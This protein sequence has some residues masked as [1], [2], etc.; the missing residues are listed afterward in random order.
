MKGILL[1]TVVA[2]TITF[3]VFGNSHQPP[4]PYEFVAG[5]V[6]QDTIPPKDRTG[7]FINNPSSNPFDLKDPSIITKEV[8][9]DPTTNRYIIIERIGDDY[10][11]AP[12]YM[13]FEEYLKYK[14]KQQEQSYFNRLAGVGK[15]DKSGL[16]ANNPLGNI[17][18][19]KNLADR[20]FGGSE[21]DIRPQGS[22]DLSFG[23]NY[24]RIENPILPERARTNIIPIDFRMNIQMNVTGSIGSKLNIN[25]NYNTQA[26]FDFD[27]IM[28]L[29]YASDAFN[30]DDIVK[31]IE[32]GN[33]SLPLKGSLIT[34]AQS[35]FGV[36]TQLQFGRLYL[37]GVASQQ[38]SDRK[39]IQ[40]KGGSQVQTY[41]VFADEY[42]EN[43]HFLLSHFN[44]E[45]FEPALENL[46]QILSL[47]TIEQI[48]VWVT[49]DR[50]E[51]AREGQPGPRDILALADLGEG[52]VLTS[53]DKVNINPASPR[54]ITGNF[55][56]PSNAVNDI[57]QTATADPQ[58]RRIERA[59]AILQNRLGF[60][61]AKDFEKVNARR[62]REGA[63]YTVNRELGFI[64]ININLRQDQVLGVAFQYSYNGR[65]YKVGELFNDQSAT[66]ADSSQQVLFVK[67]L[68]STTPRVDLPAWDLMMKNFYNIG[69]YQVNRKDFKLDVYYEDPG[70][71]Q[72]R[73]LP[74]SIGTVESRQPLI[75]LFNLDNLN[76]QGDPGQ[77]G[78]FDFVP[79]LTIYPRTGRIMFPVLEPFGSHL[80]NVRA[81]DGSPLLNEEDI[82]RFVYQ[83]LYDSTVI[84]AREFPEK[85]RF[86]VRG[87]YRSAVSSEISLGAFNIPPGSVQ[88]TAGGTLLKE[89]IDYEIDYNIGRVKI[90]ND[91]YLSS[92]V[93]I[94]ASFEDNSLFGFQTK[95]LVGLRADYKFSEEFN[96]GAT[97][98]KL[99]QR[100]FTQKVNL[101]DDP[102]NNSIYGL[103]INFSRDAPWL[104]RFVDRIP[105]IDTKA[106]SRISFNAEAAALQ[107][108]HSKAIN[109]QAGEDQGGIVYI[110]DFEGSVSS[111]DL[112]QP[113]N[114]WVISSV[115]QNDEGNNNPLFPEAALIDDIRGGANR[116]L[117]N[118]YR[119]DPQLRQTEASG[120]ENPYTT[121]I[122]LT[123]VFP[124]RQNTPDQL[125]TIQ[126]FDLA[127]YPDLRG[128]YNYDIPNGYP[129][130]SSG[131]TQS[132]ALK[133]PT[134]RWGGIMRALNINNFEQSNIQFIEFWMLSPFLNEPGNPNLEGDMYINL[135]NISEDILR[136]S[137]K[138]FENGLPGPANPNR[139]TNTTNWSVI[140]LAQQITNAFDVD[141]ATRALQDVGLDGLDSDKERE[142]YAD[143]LNSIQSSD[144]SATAKETVLNDPSNDDYR[145]YSDYPQ[146]TNILE[147]YMKFNHTEGNSQPPTD[148]AF[149]ATNIPDSEDLNRDQTLN[150]TESYF[151]FRVPIRA[152]GNGVQLNS[153]IT[154]ERTVNEGTPN[155]RKWYRYRIPLNDPA[156]R[157]SIGGIQ[158]FRSIRFMRVYLQGFAQPVVLRFARF[159]L[160][161]NQ[162]RVYQQ[163]LSN[164][165]ADFPTAFD[166]N[167]VN[168]EA[169]SS[170]CPFN[171]VLPEGIRREN[172]IGV[173]NAL[174]N[175]QSISLGV[176]N[177]ADGDARGIYKTL[178]LDMRNYERL[179]MFVHAEKLGYNECGDS[180]EDVLCDPDLN[181]GD[182]TVFVRM[183]SDFQDNYYEYEIPL[184][185]SSIENLPMLGIGQAATSAYLREIWPKENEFDFPLDWLV[186]AK[187]A[188]NK[189]GNAAE[190]FFYIPP[191]GLPQGH[192]IKVKGNPNLGYV[193]TIMIG[194]RNPK[195]DGKPHCIEIWANE[196]RLQGLNEQGGVAALARLDLQLADFGNLSLSGN[197]NSIGFGSIE[198][199]VDQR[200]LEEIKGFDIAG[201]FELS[202]FLPAAWGLRLPAYGAYS[203]LSSTP[204]FDPLDLDVLLA[205]KLANAETIQDRDSIRDLSQKVTEIKT[206]SLNNVGKQRTSQSAPM[207]WDI[208]NFSASYAFSETENRDPII[209]YDRIKNHQ[210][211]L[212]YGFN[213]R[214]K[215][216]EPFKKL[217]QSNWYKPL[218]DF[219]FNPVPN[220][221]T[222]STGMYREVSEV[223]YRFTDLDP[224]FSTFYNK[225]FT[226]DRNVGVNWDMAKSL[227][228]NFVSNGF[229]IIDEPDEARLREQ[230]L[231]PDQVREIIQDSIRTNVLVGG[232]PKNYNHSVGVNFTAP[233]RSIPILDWINL[234]AQY[235]ANYSWTAA[236]LNVQNLGNIIQNNQRR[237]VSGDFDFEKLYDKSNYL[238]QVNRAPNPNANN[239]SRRPTTPNKNDE[240]KDKKEK[241]PRKVSSSE[242]MIL[243]PL[244]A[245]RRGRLTYSED[246]ATVVPGFT[247]QTSILGLSR[248]FDAPGLDFVAGFQPNI[249]NLKPEQYGTAEDWLH[250][251]S[252]ARRENSW[253]TNDVLLNQQVAQ[254]YQ[255]NLDAQLTLEP[256]RDFR[257]DINAKR[258]FVQNHTQYFKDTL[259]VGVP[260]WVHAVPRDV[261]SLNMSYFALN[262]F[263]KDDIGEIISLFKE[264]EENRIV[265]SQLLGTG[266]HADS[267]LARQGYTDGYGRIQQDV[268]IASFIA[269]YTGKSPEE[270]KV[271]DDY[272]GNVLFKQLPFP[273]WRLT[274]SGLSKIPMFKDIFRSVNISHGY[275]SSL[276][277]NTFQTDLDFLQ[278][279]GGLNPL[280]QDFYSQLEIPEVVIQEAFAPL[281]GV[282]MRFQN[283]L[284][285]NLNFAKS[286]TLAMSFV[287]NQLAETQSQQY[288]VGAG[289]KIQNVQIG[290][291]KKMVGNTADTGGRNRDATP[292]N[293]LRQGGRRGG[294]GAN[295]NDLDI[296]IDFAWRDNVTF[297]HILDQNIT[298]PTRGTRQINFSP[299]IQYQL[300]NQLALRLFFDY[301]RTVPKI[302][303]SF[304]ITN[305]SGGIVIRFTLN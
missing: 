241:E 73:F 203:R 250:Q 268:L 138:F 149:S 70:A 220:S 278:S 217:P 129:G 65:T 245:I 78:V 121:R 14:A 266:I 180:Q 260:N 282:D 262:T 31:S 63:E 231:T 301:N 102:I 101:G 242:R 2:V 155:E 135:G 158:D 140:P 80:R 21:V 257:I 29:S 30:E 71:G 68:K 279:N 171:Y 214:T 96:I 77:D 133:D 239:S 189:D 191:T 150:E 86:V 60:Q 132:G 74:T 79:E 125:P 151:Q 281:L 163:P 224:V 148:G 137:Q 126:S 197:Y 294:G 41:E 243:R 89:G 11:R 211:S 34:G 131:L 49:N 265:V 130:I 165:L 183:G 55:L 174:Q 201:N 120:L 119:I 187:L 147:R 181:D 188:R 190:E 44:R 87:E 161:R 247:P 185:L 59:V 51:T 272:V 160:V 255:Q 139:R 212:D 64:S 166:V 32:A 259:G 234:R 85:N 107:P 7:D 18:I 170:R 58:A 40:I 19:K 13:T 289:W 25:T 178:N 267:L 276:Q 210:G 118:W 288:T 72:K 167:A 97:A 104:T 205:E 36:K 116:A 302:S 193:K 175:E 195:D 27:N 271:Q 48:D 269:S 253:I 5:T 196:L 94:R 184:Q 225:Q 22:I 76:V 207:P 226:W 222:F 75:R 228:F 141:E 263:F 164:E 50:N 4:N 54:D 95:T 24:S 83:Q 273:N 182:V 46:P 127:Y 61:Q 275:Q 304:P 20:L 218:R 8:E 93:P 26:T 156:I 230:G 252:N 45:L 223:K 284:S 52:N 244:L 56:L 67:M 221:F 254:Q 292:N 122:D 177:L 6:Q 136:D 299:S 298:D 162:W 303:S 287:S 28:K 236:A 227:K 157:R 128:P 290:F 219:N 66:G 145:Y 283:N 108:G 134:T 99:L 115:P 35:L 47:F 84:F 81:S 114:A 291:L 204:K 152:N 274:Y 300:I 215:Y 146:G 117:L 176:R 208:S 296:N 1:L 110:D 37:T 57:Y 123:E 12:T 209:E 286:R 10:Y 258:S 153:F 238:K 256:F 173:F 213:L 280:T 229:A 143:F 38:K 23:Y 100:P 198:Q 293:P 305:H 277:I 233:M 103:D 3:I 90:L 285:I 154:D 179:K 105:G 206:V 235:N 91:A 111:I 186:E 17:D 15:T 192:I 88:V 202:R 62:L 124:N 249:R 297:N 144:L 113:A 98:L 246:F 216:I 92:G 168:I 33:V 109:E 9:Y 232:R 237:Q 270:A 248:G 264:F 69:A 112:R 42:D 199:R 159:E 39:E 194:L 240:N 251:I 82:N 261:G 295:V 169:N 43:R 172:N 142:K 106:P 16:G 53:P 200:S